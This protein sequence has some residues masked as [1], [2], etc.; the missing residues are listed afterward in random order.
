[1]VISFFQ[2]YTRNIIDTTYITGHSDRLYIFPSSKSKDISIIN[3]KYSSL[4]R[5]LK[6][7]EF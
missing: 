2:R 7:E 6:S 5:I 3:H 4:C 1:M